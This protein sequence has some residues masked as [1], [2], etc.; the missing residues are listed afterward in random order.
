MSSTKEEKR[1][2]F[3]F[4]VYEFDTADGGVDHK[5]EVVG[6]YGGLNLQF[7]STVDQVRD[8]FTKRRERKTGLSAV[9]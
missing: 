1:L 2:V 6:N 7:T 5:I 9:K 4:E 8:F 3:S